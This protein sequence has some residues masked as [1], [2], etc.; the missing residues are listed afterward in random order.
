MA[1]LFSHGNSVDFCITKVP[2]VDDC[3]TWIGRSGNP[4]ILGKNVRL[5]NT[6]PPNEKLSASNNRNFEDLE[7][8]AVSLLL[9]QF[10][11]SRESN[12]LL[13]CKCT[14]CWQL[15]QT[16]QSKEDI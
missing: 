16:R 2:N 6:A 13:K 3:I 8:S 10:H 14:G 5:I 12:L 9:S 4:V 7:L 11:Q 15:I 1:N